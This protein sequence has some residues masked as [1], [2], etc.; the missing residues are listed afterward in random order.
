MRGI[1]FL[2]V[3]AT[4][5]PVSAHADEAA[6]SA[7]REPGTHVIMRHARAPGTGDPPDFRL[8][9]CSTQRNLDDTGRDQAR[10]IGTGIRDAGI[11]V[12]V[13]LSSAWCRATETA[14]LLDVG[15]VETESS[16]NSFFENRD[17]GPATTDRLRGR[18]AELEGRKAVLVTHQVNITALTGVFPASG[19]MIVIA[20]EPDGDVAVRGRIGPP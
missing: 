12:D 11:A 14:R 19:E 6:W 5:L 2:A 9:D 8:G 16:L 13:V 15:T 1:A 3:L 18:L 17:L 20:V 4:A 10:R 7:F